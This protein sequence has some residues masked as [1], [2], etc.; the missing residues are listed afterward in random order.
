MG[1]LN[2]GGAGL[3]ASRLWRHHTGTKEGGAAGDP[4]QY[5]AERN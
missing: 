2:Q 4:A 3:L 5:T 1:F